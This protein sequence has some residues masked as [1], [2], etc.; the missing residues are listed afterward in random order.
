[1]SLNL[2]TDS[3]IG[4]WNW[5][6]AAPELLQAHGQGTLSLGTNSALTSRHYCDASGGISV[7]SFST[8]AGVRTTFITHGI[9]VVANMQLAS[10]IV[11]GDYCLVSSN[12]NFVPGSSIP[13]FTL[14]A[15]GS[16]IHKKHFDPGWLLAGVP[17][18][19]KRRV[20]QNTGYFARTLGVVGAGAARLEL[21]ID[22][23]GPDVESG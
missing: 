5:V 17:V 20:N 22:A 2:G 10:G 4:Q 3:I 21:E 8:V 13:D 6:S 12:C 18:G 1:V 11:I 19:P 15:M 14:V 7:G 9:D 23:M 16:T